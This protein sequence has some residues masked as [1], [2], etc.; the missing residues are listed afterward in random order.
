[1]NPTHTTIRA[2]LQDIVR[3]HEL[4]PCEEYLK[5]SARI[6]RSIVQNLSVIDSLL[7]YE[8]TPPPF[9]PFL[10]KELITPEP[11]DPSLPYLAD[12]TFHQ[13]SIHT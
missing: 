4:A 2:I 5:N 10:V 11:A 13:W 9:V 6:R 3:A 12:N 7:S 8:E 1:M